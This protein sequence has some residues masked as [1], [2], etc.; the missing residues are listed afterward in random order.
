RF[1]RAP[2]TDGAMRQCS[3]YHYA[4]W[5]GKGST[6][7]RK[8]KL[9]G[10]MFFGTGPREPVFV[11]PGADGDGAARRRRRLRVKRLRSGAGAE[12]KSDDPRQDRLPVRQVVGL[13]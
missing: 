5:S 4:A 6:K 7:K 13:G 3:G 9:S 2:C 1:G 8:E 10:Q 12:V 11:S